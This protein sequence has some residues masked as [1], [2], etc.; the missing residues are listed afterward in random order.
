MRKQ[1][2]ALIVLVCIALAGVVLL[3]VDGCREE[4]TAAPGPPATSAPKWNAANPPPLPPYEWPDAFRLP[5]HPEIVIDDVPEVP[6]EIR[7]P[8]PPIGS[9]GDQ[10]DIDTET[11]RFVNH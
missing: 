10:S 3:C 9:K 4:P 2:I 1:W 11:G 7:G 5:P 8:S 6:E